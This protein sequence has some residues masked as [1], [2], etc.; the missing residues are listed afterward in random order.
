MIRS[1]PFK[2]ICTGKLNFLFKTIASISI[3]PVEAL[4]LKTR[5]IPTPIKHPAIT[6]ASKGS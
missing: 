5:P 1:I 6:L 2:T 4:H 3:P